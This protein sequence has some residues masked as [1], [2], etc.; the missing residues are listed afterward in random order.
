MGELFIYNKH[1][2]NLKKNSLWMQI[3][4]HLLPLIGPDI[5]TLKHKKMPLALLY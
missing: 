1:I 5:I 4:S 3:S 2:K